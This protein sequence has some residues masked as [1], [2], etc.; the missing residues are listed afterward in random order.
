VAAPLLASAVLPGLNAPAA[1]VANA[2]MVEAGALVRSLI[3]GLARINAAAVWIFARAAADFELSSAWLTCLGTVGLS[4]VGGYFLGARAVPNLKG[5]VK[6][7]RWPEELTSGAPV[8][9]GFRRATAAQARDMKRIHPGS[10][11][12]LSHDLDTGAGATLG[13][14]YDEAQHIAVGAPGFGV[15]GIYVGHAHTTM[16]ENAARQLA[17]GRDTPGKWLPALRTAAGNWVFAE[18][19]TVDTIKHGR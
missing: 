15:A 13:K 5:S 12:T 16:H 9:S 10:I 4:A 7:L 18:E 1:Y 8:P 14:A 2:T 19:A 11:T 17:A 3:A 6:P